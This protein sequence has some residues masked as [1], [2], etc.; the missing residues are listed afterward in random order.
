MSRTFLITSLVIFGL[1]EIIVALCCGFWFVT[2]IRSVE[3][4][5]QSIV[6]FL[7]NQNSTAQPAAKK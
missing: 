5:Q 7:Q 6:Q 1:L 3:L 2:R 4:G